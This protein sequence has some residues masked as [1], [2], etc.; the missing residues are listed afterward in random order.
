MIQQAVA[1][2]VGGQGGGGNPAAPGGGPVG[3]GAKLKIDPTMVYLKI[4]RLEKLMLHMF[5]QCG[6]N[7][8]PDILNDDAMIQAATGQPSSSATTPPAAARRRMPEA[9]SKA[10]RPY[11]A[12]RP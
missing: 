5:E 12:R 8:P 6:W 3:V 11:L 2:A 10:C 7:L 4:G 9:D 1:Q